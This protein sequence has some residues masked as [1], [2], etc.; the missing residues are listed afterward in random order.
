MVL[1]RIIGVLGGLLRRTKPN[2]SDST[3]TG[4]VGTILTNSGNVR[5]QQANQDLADAIKTLSHS[6]TMVVQ[7]P[8]VEAKLQSLGSLDLGTMPIEEI[9]ELA[10]LHFEGSP[11]IEKDQNRAFELWKAAAERGSLEAKYSCAL[12]MKDGIGTEKNC[13][14]AA[15]ELRVL[16][17]EKNYNLA[18]VR[19]CYIEKK[20]LYY[21]YLISF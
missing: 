9:E 11:L 20:R 3:Q 19:R 15:E 6:N 8:D 5:V 10:R 4:V 2:G 7:R 18:H 12:C 17:E 14:T 21:T 16:S 13:V 1:K